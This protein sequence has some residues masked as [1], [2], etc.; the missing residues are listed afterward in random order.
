MAFTFC[1]Y[2]HTKEDRPKQVN[3][4]QRFRVECS[5]DNRILGEKIGV[6]Y[7]FPWTKGQEK[8]PL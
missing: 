6:G 5:E 8:S 4:R 3:K 2:T 7:P 1:K